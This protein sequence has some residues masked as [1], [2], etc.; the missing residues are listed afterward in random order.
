LLRAA[1]AIVCLNE[2]AREHIAERTGDPGKIF[3]VPNFPADR[4]DS[5]SEIEQGLDALYVGRLSSEKGI[6]QV[7]EVW[8]EG[9][10]LAIVG[11]GPDSDRVRRLVERRADLESLG[12]MTPGMVRAAMKRARLLLVPSMCP[13]GFPTVILE[14]MQEGLP[15]VVSDHVAVA[16]ELRMR[17]AAEVF[18]MSDPTTLAAA[19]TRVAQ[20]ES[21]MRQHARQAFDEHYSRRAWSERMLQVYG[22][23]CRRS[24]DRR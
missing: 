10:R 7:L 20:R 23:A 21:D 16:D 22:A 6:L 19:L 8:P 24:S 1:D 17:G 4:A 15:V 18:S 3:V 5:A 9:R 12:Q 13:E 2:T 11:E 14:A